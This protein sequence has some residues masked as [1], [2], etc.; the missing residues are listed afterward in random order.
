[1]LRCFSCVYLLLIAFSPSSQV[2]GGEHVGLGGGFK[3]AV[4]AHED[5]GEE[6]E[7]RSNQIEDRESE[8]EG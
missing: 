6:E 3:G 1:M 2:D 8:E 7:C 4:K 5:V